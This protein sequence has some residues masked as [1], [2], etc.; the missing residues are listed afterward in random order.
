MPP[1]CSTLHVV[2]ST[3][4]SLSCSFDQIREVGRNK[5]FV[6]LRQAN[7]SNAVRHSR[8]QTYF[9]VD[10]FMNVRCDRE[11][12]LMWWSFS[13][14]LIFGFSLHFSVLRAIS[15]F[16][17][18]LDSVVDR[19]N[20]NLAVVCYCS[21]RYNC[22]LQSRHIQ[23]RVQCLRMPFLVG[24]PLR[25]LRKGIDCRRKSSRSMPFE[26]TRSA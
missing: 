20:R 25:V 15:V 5:S 1:Q 24:D 9:L 17:V 3:L 10:N 7:K 4:V 26:C 18:Q 14:Q 16:S 23:R 2:N 11:Q 6:T 22:I 13:F 19:F 12:Q 21:N 8:K